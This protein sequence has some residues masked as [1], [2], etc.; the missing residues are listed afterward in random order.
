MSC[1]RFVPE[2]DTRL[3]LLVAAAE[4]CE[5]AAQ[6]HKAEDLY[7]L[8]GKGAA[9]ILMFGY[10]SRDAYYCFLLIGSFGRALAITNRK[11]ATLLHGSEL[12]VTS[13]RKNLNTSSELEGV[14]QKGQQLMESAK[15]EPGT[16][17]GV[18]EL[19]VHWRHVMLHAIVSVG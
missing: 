8:A 12:S 11:L 5:Q 17:T 10:G 6:Y 18:Y 3:Q 4:D 1:C 7:Q 19:H 13:T 14:L 16:G 15:L 2:G 9:P